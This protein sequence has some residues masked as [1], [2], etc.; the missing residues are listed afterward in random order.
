MIKKEKDNKFSYKFLCLGEP[1]NEITHLHLYYKDKKIEIYIWKLRYNIEKFRFYCLKQITK[2]NPGSEILC[3]EAFE[4][5]D[6]FLE[7]YKE[8]WK[9]LKKQIKEGK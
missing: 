5:L 3:Y 1:K 2:N 6:Y 4:I 8:I 9:D 7:N